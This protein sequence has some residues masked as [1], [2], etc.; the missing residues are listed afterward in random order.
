METESD[1]FNQKCPMCNN[2]SRKLGYAGLKSGVTKPKYQCTICAR[3]FTEGTVIP[4]HIR[5]E[6]L[7]NLIK[8]ITMVRDELLNDNIK[9]AQHE[10]GDHMVNK[11]VK[12]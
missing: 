8:N 11:P 6:Y 1:D 12:I 2:K 4:L 10:E 3:H 7:N 5:L 9:E